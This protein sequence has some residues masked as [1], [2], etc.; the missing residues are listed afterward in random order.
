MEEGKGS[1]IFEEESRQDCRNYCRI[2]VMSAMS[3]E[4]PEKA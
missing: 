3:M 1:F 2:S 4:K